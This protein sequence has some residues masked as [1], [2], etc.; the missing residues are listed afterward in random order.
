MKNCTFAL[1]LRC[2][3]GLWTP[4][5]ACASTGTAFRHWFPPTRHSPLPVRAYRTPTH[6]QHHTPTTF[7][8][9]QW[10]ACYGTWRRTTH[11]PA[12]TCFLRPYTAL[13]L[14]GVAAYHLRHALPRTHTDADARAVSPVY[15]P[16]CPPTR[17]YLPALMPPACCAMPTPY[18]R[19]TLFNRRT[20]GLPACF[21]ISGARLLAL[22]RLCCVFCGLNQA[23]WHEIGGV[24]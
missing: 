14:R 1:V 21:S 16:A 9:Q 13:F 5:T 18:C 12:L 20:F 19:A 23:A 15:R 22:V 24:A 10:D 11:R 8:T 7:A 17:R 4:I 6:Q 2:S 3:L